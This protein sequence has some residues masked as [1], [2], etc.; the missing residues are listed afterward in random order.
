M[1]ATVLPNPLRRDM[2]A[3][4]GYMVRRAAQVRSLM[5]KLGPIEFDRPEGG[6]DKD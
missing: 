3:P 2:A 5:G 4:S 6:N 1:I